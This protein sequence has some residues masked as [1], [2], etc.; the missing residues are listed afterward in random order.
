M[1]ECHGPSAQ[2]LRQSGALGERDGFRELNRTMGGEDGVG[3]EGGTV[4]ILGEKGVRETDDAVTGL[5]GRHR[6]ADLDDDTGDI[7]DYMSGLETIRKI[8]RAEQQPEI[9]WCLT[10]AEDHWV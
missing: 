5:E 7:C 4:V 9:K 10:R 1:K 3:L 2:G 8:S 6:R